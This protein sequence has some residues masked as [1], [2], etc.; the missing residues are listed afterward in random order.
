MSVITCNY[1]D[2]CPCWCLPLFL[3]LCGICIFRLFITVIVSKMFRYDHTFS[4]ICQLGNVVALRRSDAAE[5]CCGSVPA[6]RRCHELRLPAPVLAARIWRSHLHVR[7]WNNH[8]CTS[9]STGPA[10]LCSG[11]S[12][13]LRFASFCSGPSSLLRFASFC[14]NTS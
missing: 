1:I 14:I 10:S 12:S 2:A 3:C 5:R 6:R 11:P 8:F 9:S 4:K 13:L 7:G